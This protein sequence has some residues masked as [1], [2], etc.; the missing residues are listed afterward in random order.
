MALSGAPSP[1]LNMVL[2]SGGDQST[3]DLVVGRVNE[4]EV[5]TLFMLAGDCEECSLTTEWQPVG[6]MPFMISDLDSDQLRADPRV[7]QAVFE[8]LDLVCSVTG[9]AFGLASDLLSPVVAGI[10][11]DEH[12]STKFW[13]LQEDQEA[14]SAVLTSI[15]DDSV[16][17]FCMSTP[18]RFA[19][20]GYGRAILADTLHR[21]KAQG[22]KVGLLGATPVGRPLYDATGWRTIETWRMFAIGESVQFGH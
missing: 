2:V 22:A 5:P 3:V 4:S 10:L 6:E 8:D 16:S 9:A 15:V 13:L 19:R 17:V 1:D 12:G 18:E 7:R 20:R 14:V 11:R 21:A